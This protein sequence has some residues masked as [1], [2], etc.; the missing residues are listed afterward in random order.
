MPS[1]RCKHSEQEMSP[2]VEDIQNKTSSKK[3]RTHEKTPAKYKEQPLNNVEPEKTRESRKVECNNAEVGG[4][5]EDQETGDISAESQDLFM[6]PLKQIDNNKH[7]C[8][9]TK[10]KIEAK[11]D[12]KVIVPGQEKNAENRDIED[13]KKYHLLRLKLSKYKKNISDPV[14]SGVKSN[15]NKIKPLC[16]DLEKRQ[17]SSWEVR[18]EDLKDDNT[19]KLPLENP[20]LQI[21]E[22]IISEK[23]GHVHSVGQAVVF[24]RQ[25]KSE[26]KDENLILCEDK[27]SKALN[28]KDMAGISTVLSISQTSSG[29]SVSTVFDNDPMALSGD[30]IKTRRRSGSRKRSLSGQSIQRRSSRL[31]EQS[32]QDSSSQFTEMEVTSPLFLNAG[33]SSAKKRVIISS[34]FQ[35]LVDECRRKL[36]VEEFRVPS[37]YV[38]CDLI[39]KN[40]LELN[41][42]GGPSTIE[43]HYSNTDPK[44]IEERGIKTIFDSKSEFHEEN[45]TISTEHVK[46]PHSFIGTN[47]EKEEIISP[48]LFGSQSDTSS[49]KFENENSENEEKSDSSSN[50]GEKEPKHGNETDNYKSECKGPS[51]PNNKVYCVDSGGKE[52]SLYLHQ[53]ASFQVRQNLVSV[54]Y[55]VPF[56]YPNYNVVV[57]NTKTFFKEIKH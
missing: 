15:E 3:V 25:V 18:P 30:N 39:N 24:E 47:S 1:D 14:K 32:S 23:Q 17:R 11:S 43:S 13:R 31:A 56:P 2:N 44:D 26:N 51:V 45:K 28:Q 46:S 10:T 50:K 21:S 42:Q 53:T 48:T 16:A 6:T 7:V 55:C 29:S 49:F 12:D 57:F 4:V 22:D 5:D 36:S 38:H 20:T 41:N 27:G 9:H 35:C 40:S 54:Q 34:V 52:S 37:D 33:H 8:L 19:G